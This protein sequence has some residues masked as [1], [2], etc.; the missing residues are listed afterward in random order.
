MYS[1]LKKC[2]IC[3][4]DLLQ[5]LDLGNQYVVDFVPDK[6]EKLLKAP[7]ILNCCNNCSFV[8]LKHRVSPDRLYRKF[9][10]RSGINEQMKSE[11]LA[12][13]QHTQDVVELKQGDKVLDIGCNDGTMLGCY[14]KGIQTWGVDPC[15]D[16][17]KEGIQSGNIDIGITDYFNEEALYRVN[18]ALSVS[19]P[20]FKIITAIAMF[21][22]VEDPVQFLKDCKTFLHEDGVIVIQMNYLVSMLEMVAFDNI[23]HEHLGY[24]SLMSLNR[25]VDKAGLELQGIELSKSNGGSIRAYITYRNPMSFCA[26]NAQHRLWLHTNAELKLLKEMRMQLNTDVPFNTFRESVERRKKS[27]LD[28]LM[29]IKDKKVYAYGA[30]TR[31]TVTSQYIF[32]NGA[33]DQIL[34]VAERDTHKYG[35]RMVGTWWPIVAEDEA[36]KQA[37]YFIVL[38]WHFKDS[39][40]KREEEWLKNGGKMIFPLP[41]PMAVERDTDAIFATTGKLI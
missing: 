32:E 31:G 2:I 16:L 29:T 3:G 7:L 11:L 17:V 39:I 1:E 14:F 35:L 4:S 18:K 6:N 20:K 37:D 28:Y 40:I 26:K 24:Y 19:P 34:G 38:P 9:W 30:S 12:I 13:V 33:G 5:I 8:Q 10:Y 27:V 25:A 23:C 22:D 21:Y 15:G 36:R 41:D